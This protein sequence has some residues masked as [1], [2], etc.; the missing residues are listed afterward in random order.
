MNHT[1]YLHWTLVYWLSPNALIDILGYPASILR[2][3]MPTKLTELPSTGDSETKASG[4]CVLNPNPALTASC[5]L[6][7]NQMFFNIKLSELSCKSTYLSL[8]MYR[9]RFSSNFSGA[10]TVYT[11]S[12]SGSPSVV[13]AS[14]SP[15]SRVSYSTSCQYDGSDTSSKLEFWSSICRS[16]VVDH[17]NPL[18]LDWNWLVVFSH[19]SEKYEFVHW[20]D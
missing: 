2:Q 17:L 8:T 5:R 15:C 10:S 19:P 1:I 16:H 14:S 6:S 11:C 12:G 20:D 18:N 4:C 3:P 9:S 13:W 7:P